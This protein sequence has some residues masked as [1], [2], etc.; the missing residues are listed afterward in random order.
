MHI[1]DSND[2]YLCPE[3][4]NRHWKGD[5]LLRVCVTVGSR[6]SIQQKYPVRVMTLRL[7]L[8]IQKLLLRL[9]IMCIIVAVCAGYFS[10]LVL[11]VTNANSGTSLSIHVSSVISLSLYNTLPHHRL[12]SVVVINCSHHSSML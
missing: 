4:G 7:F 2:T 8:T 1:D 5:G 9:F 3:M 6:P 12:Q 11:F 10:N